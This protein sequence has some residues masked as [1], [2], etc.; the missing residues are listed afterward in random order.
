MHSPVMRDSSHTVIAG[1][2]IAVNAWR[3]REGWSRETVVARIVVQYE[4]LG[5]PALTGIVFDPE[6][7]DAYDRMRVNADRVYAGWI[8]KQRMATCCRPTFCL[9]CWQRCRWICACR[10]STRCWRARACM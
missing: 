6:T 10:P 4:K 7:R 3:K 9:L 5:G 1:V 2:R 8:M